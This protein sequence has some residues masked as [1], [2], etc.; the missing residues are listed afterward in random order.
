M[1]FG[2]LDDLTRLEEPIAALPCD[3]EGTRGPGRCGRRIAG[4]DTPRAMG[5]RSDDSLAR[6]TLSI[7]RGS[8]FVARGSLFAVGVRASW[9]WFDNFKNHRFSC[10][11]PI[12]RIFDV[13]V[14]PFSST[15]A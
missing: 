12:L 9:L 8:L 5:S 15:V 11:S 6:S 2:A 1:R 4:H 3:V 13:S 10:G 14:G 7:F